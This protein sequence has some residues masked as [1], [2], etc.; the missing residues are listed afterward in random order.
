MK[1]HHINASTIMDM[2]AVVIFL[3]VCAWGL[4]SW[5]E[6]VTNNMTP[7]Y[8]YSAWNLFEILF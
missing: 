5:H 3:I 6:V 4:M 2:I 7:G 1:K 8:V